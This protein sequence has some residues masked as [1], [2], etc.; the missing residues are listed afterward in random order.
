MVIRLGEEK[1]K[2]LRIDQGLFKLT[3]LRGSAVSILLSLLVIGCMGD[4]DQEPIEA[5]SCPSGK[6]DRVSDDVQEL[7]SDMKRVSLDDLVS[8]GAGLATE[9]L[10]DQL[11]R[12]PFI[13]LQL[14]ETSLFG[15]ETRTLF[16]ETMINNIYDLQAGLTVALGEQAFSAKVN[17][18]RISTL[19][20]RPGSIFAETS[21]RLGGS[22]QQSW[23][24]DHGEW[25]GNL[26]FELSP[27]LEAIVIAPYDQVSDAVVSQPLNLLRAARGFIL[28][29]D[30]SDI[31]NMSAGSSV[32]LRGRGVVGIN[33]GLGVPLIATAIGDYLSLN[34]RLSGAVRVSMSGDLDVQL[35]RGQGSTVYLDVGLTEQR[36][37]HLSAA[38]TSG[39]GVEGLPIPELNVG[40]L[41]VDV[42]QVIEEAFARQLNEKLGAFDVRRS[43]TQVS[44]RLSV[45]RFEFNLSAATP[46]L[47]QALIQ[48]LKGD[49]RL[50]Q[51][52]ANRDQ[53]G[54]VSQLELTKDFELDSK[55]LGFRLLSMRFFSST[56]ETQGNINIGVNGENQEILFGEIERKGGIFFT[57]RG[58]NW[59][60]TT[61]TISS[62]MGPK[63]ALNNARLIITEHDRFLSKDQINDH[64]DALLGYFYGANPVFE[65]FGY[66]ADQLSE[67][68]DHSCGGRPDHDAS[69]REKERYET[70]VEQLPFDPQVRSYI[71]RIYE[72]SSG[73]EGRWSGQDFSLLDAT[74]VGQ[75]VLATRVGISAT[76]DAPNVGM[77][78][79]R[80]T[81]VTQ[82]RFSDQAVETLM[83]P[84]SPE[85]FAK[86]MMSVMSL[87]DLDRG[88]DLDD[89]IDERDNYLRGK[90]RRISEVVDTYQVIMERYQQYNEVAE[91]TWND[92]KSVGEEATL[93]LISRDEK[94]ALKSLAQ[95]KGELIGTLYGELIESARWLGEPDTLLVGYALLN[96]VPPSQIELMLSGKFSEDHSGGYHQYDYSIYSLGNADFIEAG[97]FNLEEL[98][99]AKSL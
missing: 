88:D 28:P 51:A 74:T 43:S 57:Q 44:G 78:G 73:Y 40:G 25:L 2:C 82:V 32:T 6:C 76:H 53:S 68:A 21:F 62:G 1:M 92:G 8:L 33:L 11:A 66:I 27:N 36:V 19:Q 22:L 77:T 95:L 63:R 83:D 5:G 60:Q 9:E 46:T 99:S 54:V 16:G 7:F 69:R 10:N 67:H 85:R 91:L 4:V 30:L 94:P 14:S 87:M 20:S 17:Q 70:C 58:S 61:S 97:I 35:V 31:I 64:L 29:R 12:L 71:D 72:R 52:L 24:V 26:G 34:A 15:L 80:G 75:Q 41:K 13:D 23:S 45:A 47:T 48:G 89:R 59:R 50:A 39:Y 65:D 93:L 98:L 79:P 49:L 96:L 56:E 81:L 42:A 86:A 37:K 55:Y 18:L 38:V 84:S 90:Q 3:H